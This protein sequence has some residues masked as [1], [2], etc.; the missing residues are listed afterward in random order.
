MQQPLLYIDG[1]RADG[2]LHSIGLDVGGQAPSRLDDISIDDVDCV[3]VL[4]GP[5]A[6]ASYGMDASGGVIHVV[7]HKPRRAGRTLQVFLQGGATTDNADYP[8]NFGTEGS[9]LYGGCT[10]SDAALGRC[11]AGA[12]RS[13]NPMDAVSPFRV[14]PIVNGGARGGL[15]LGRRLTLGMTARASLSNGHFRTNDSERHAMTAAA[16]W[17]PVTALQ[18]TTDGWFFGGRTTLPE[19]GVAGRLAVLANALWGTNADDSVRRGYRY[20]PLAILE[21]FGID[22]NVG[23][24][25]G[26]FR[27]RFAP[28]EWLSFTL[29]AGR[30]DSR[31]S[32]ERD[33]PGFR[34]SQLPNLELGRAVGEAELRNQQTTLSATA[35][36]TYGVH[37]VRFTTELGVDR[38]DQTTRKW[39][40]LRYVLPPG[41]A[42]SSSSRWRAGNAT[43]D[44]V[45]VRQSVAIG[46]RLFVDGGVRREKLDWS[47]LDL[48]DPTSPYAS[49]LLHVLR[50]SRDRRGLT[51][52]A[53][54]AA[55]G[56]TSDRRPWDIAI[57][58]ARVLVGT[59]SR[60]VPKPVLENTRELEG[61]FDV[62]LLRDNVRLNATYF[63]KRTSDGLMP[64]SVFGSSGVF[65]T[66][67]NQAEWKSTG[68][69]LLL[70][71]R[72]PNVSGVVAGLGVNYATLDNEITTLGA[73]P[74]SSL[75]FYTRNF[76][77][78]PIGGWWIYPFTVS[79]QNGDGVIVPTEVTTN[80]EF[81]YWGSPVPTREIGLTPSLR[82]VAALSIAALVDYRGGFRKLNLSGETRC[83]ANCSDLYLPNV[84]FEH[85]ARAVDDGDAFSGWFEDASFIKLREVSATWALPKAWARRIGARASRVVL[86]ARDLATF[87][88]Y[89]GLDPETTS[90]GQSRMY[91]LDNFTPPL[92]RSVTLRLDLGW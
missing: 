21:Q 86:S 17:R 35:R 27:A 20:A 6:A 68:I 52:F 36:S 46:D 18:I 50:E 81:Q 66:V 54:R 44:G 90:Q 4:R 49:A 48:N 38:L 37:I 83:I 47:P 15:E 16:E 67:V 82:F 63:S 31:T 85:Q 19:V 8:S 53:L 23:R 22:Q 72:S 71:L 77:G 2:E 91:Q 39:S 28:G 43:I 24:I 5:A 56:E 75:G 84:S 80:R 45:F 59:P 41:P 65:T 64:V 58:S 30:E 62:G 70:R 60:P 25:G 61:G 26:V 1:V 55:Y 51:S 89:S 87:T 32:D 88:D 12:V 73:F 13:W 29:T 9:G 14:G 79:D 7:T 34:E 78:Y 69:E 11:V 42:V 33:D 76:V 57:D 3:Y 40:A 74:G 10:R 92:P